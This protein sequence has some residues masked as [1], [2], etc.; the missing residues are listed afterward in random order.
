MISTIKACLFLA[1]ASFI[2]AGF[3]L[4]VCSFLPF[5][6]LKHNL[7]VLAS[8]FSLTNS[9]SATFF[10]PSFYEQIVV[11]CRFIGVALLLGGGILYVCIGRIQQHIEGIITQFFSFSRE[12]LQNVGETIKREDRIHPGALLSLLLLAVAVRLCAL[13]RLLRSQL[14]WPSPC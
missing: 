5:E 11:R 4:F 10:T 8:A 13:M 9:R 2:V 6:L 14:M 3:A 7:D 12:L 1:A